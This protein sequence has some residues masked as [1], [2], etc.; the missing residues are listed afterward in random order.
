MFRRGADMRQQ[1]SDAIAGPSSLSSEK[2]LISAYVN[3]LRRTVRFSQIRWATKEAANLAH[4]CAD[5]GHVS[6][7][8]RFD[9]K[10]RG[11]G[12]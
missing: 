5:A 9:R 3:G 12:R 4:Y 6:A 2:E 7:L 10:A 11:G 8:D 1:G